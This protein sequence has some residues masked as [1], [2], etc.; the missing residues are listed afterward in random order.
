MYRSLR[1]RLAKE[2]TFRAF[3]LALSASVFV[4]KAVGSQ[5]GYVD[6][7]LY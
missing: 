6:V 4:L 3:K 2:A 7:I 1:R 5:G